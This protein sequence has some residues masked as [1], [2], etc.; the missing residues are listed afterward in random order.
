MRLE[1][2]TVKLDDFPELVV[3]YL[4]M[5]VRRPKGLLRLL[6]L[7]PQIQKA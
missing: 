5:Y 4:G 2:Q 6:G 7:G 3:I 1:R